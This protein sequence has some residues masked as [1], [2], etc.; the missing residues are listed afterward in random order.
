MSA[1][2]QILGEASTREELIRFRWHQA[3]L[4]AMKFRDVDDKELR[5]RLAALNVEVTRQAVESWTAGKTCPR[6][7]IQEAIGTALDMPAREIFPLENLP[8]P[9]DG[10]AVA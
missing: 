8:K 4:R 2:V 10:Q 6:P 9:S 7:H 1:V 5:R 3:L